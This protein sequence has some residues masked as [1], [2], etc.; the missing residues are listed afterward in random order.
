M[1]EWTRHQGRKIKKANE[2]KEEQGKENPWC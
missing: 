1:S 2:G